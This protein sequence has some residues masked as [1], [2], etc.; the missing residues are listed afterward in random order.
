[1]G[2]YPGLPSIS[3]QSSGESSLDDSTGPVDAFC[4]LVLNPEQV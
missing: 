3:E 4:L 1:M 2:P